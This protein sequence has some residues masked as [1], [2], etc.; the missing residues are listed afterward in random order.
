VISATAEL[1]LEFLDALGLT[2]EEEDR[3]NHLLDVETQL[4]GCGRLG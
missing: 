2:L 4:G 1:H 3:S